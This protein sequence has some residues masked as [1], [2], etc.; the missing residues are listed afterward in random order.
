MA[1]LKRKH[2]I[3]EGKKKSASIVESGEESG[4]ASAPKHLKTEP[5]PMAQDKVFTGSRCIAANIVV[6]RRHSRLDRDMILI[7]AEGLMVLVSE[8]PLGVDDLYEILNKSFWIRTLWKRLLKDQKGYRV[9]DSDELLDLEEE[10]H[11]DIIPRAESVGILDLN[12]MIKIPMPKLDLEKETEKECHRQAT[13]KIRAKTWEKDEKV[14]SE[15]EMYKDL[16]LVLVQEMEKE[17]EKDVK[18]VD[19][20]DAS[21][22]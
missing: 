18:I 1:K 9:E 2:K 4:N 7:K 15:V 14:E 6:S 5:E 12:M 13:A 16:E 8:L 10:I 21:V 17:K 22:S 20:S 19:L 3:A 11:Q